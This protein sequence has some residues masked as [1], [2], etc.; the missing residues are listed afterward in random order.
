MQE[1]KL[2]DLSDDQWM[3]N[4]LADTAYA[5]IDVEGELQ[6]F[7]RWCSEKDVI[8][9]RSRFTSWLQKSE[10]P[11]AY[12]RRRKQ[13]EP[14]VDV[15]AAPPEDWR[16]RIDQSYR[17]WQ[18]LEIPVNLRRAALLAVLAQQKVTS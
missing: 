2:M 15:Y 11:L 1:S 12:K 10:P 7:Y 9:T 17:H 4:L 16:E 6:S 14:Q 3:L 13:E 18:W 5:D 8:P